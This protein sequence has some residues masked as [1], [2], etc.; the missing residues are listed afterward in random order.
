[1]SQTW[2]LDDAP[3]HLLKSGAPTSDQPISLLKFSKILGIAH[4]SQAAWIEKLPFACDDVTAGSESELQAA[5]V[6]DRSSVDLAQTIEHSTYYRNLSKRAASGDLPPRNLA[7]L[8]TYLASSKD[9][10]E[11]SWIRFPRHL[12]NRHAR[13]I[14]ALD[15]R[16]DKGRRDSP[17]RSDVADFEVIQNATTWLRIPISYL[18]KLSLAQVIGQP[19]TPPMV[20]QTGEKMLSC[21]LN[22]N[23]SPETHSFSP[24]GRGQKKSL[25]SAIAHETQRRYLLT[26][27]LTQYANQVFEL[28]ENGQKALVYFC[29]H[30]PIRQKQLNELISDA[31]YRHLFMSPCLSGWDRGEEK[32]RYMSLCHMALSRSQINTLAKLKEAGII[33][34]NLVVLPNTSNICLANNST[35]LSLGSRRLTAMLKNDTDFHAADEKYYGDLVIK[36]SEHFLPLFAGTYSAAPYRFDFKDFHPEKVL[37]FLPHEL[38]YTHL[39]MLWRRWKQKAHIKL[40][41]NP[42]TPF[43]PEWLDR[44]FSRIAGLKGDWVPDF[45]LIDYLVCL[46]STDESPALN[47]QLDNDVRLKSDLAA[48]GIFDQRMPL[49]LPYRLRQ[50]G[51]MGFSGFEARY[52]SLF[53]RFGKDMA[54]AVDLQHLITLLAYKYILQRRLMHI[55]IPDSPTVESERRYLFFGSAIGIPTFYILKSNPDRLMDDILRKARHTRTSRRYPR[56]IRVTAQ[57]YRRALLRLLREDGQDLIDML[58]LEPVVSDLEARLEHPREHDAAHRICRRVLGP[59]KSAPLK[60]PATEFNQAVEAFYREP[61]RKNHLEE[62]LSV[63]KQEVGRLDA[64]QTWRGGTYNAALMK[65]LDGRDAVDFVQN[66]ERQA[67]EEELPAHVCLKLIQLVLLV[68][69][70]QNRNPAD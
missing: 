54:P 64:W 38:D 26:Q 48:M 53:E 29:P 12:L 24:V 33:A 20:R 10:W 46:L 59:D 34:N 50:F 61:L 22:D 2:S 51:Q 9:I 14:L 28:A 58:N 3:L 17:L 8:D 56:Y 47:G 16:A 57:E 1:M 27:L 43:G 25:G 13:E 32:H 60:L 37:G 70:H 45:R 44:R 62:A 68:Y 11:N 67:V 31:F 7:M 15:L 40:F 52:Y 5:V 35:H 55:D 19:D 66:I 23:T 42:V 36:I 69:H 65:I 4:P 63:F 18:L 21:L 39:R 49:Y 41:G 30:P 6:G